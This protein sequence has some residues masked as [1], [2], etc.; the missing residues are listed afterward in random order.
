MHIALSCSAVIGPPIGGFPSC[1]PG[2]LPSWRYGSRWPGPA[3]ARGARQAARRRRGRTT[4][5]GW[6]AIAG[7]DVGEIA[8]T[9]PTGGTAARQRRQH[10]PIAPKRAM[11][12][13]DRQPRS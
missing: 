11:W 2:R 9:L 12:R 8:A 5:A 3:A 13:S 6:Q 4:A 1:P 7:A 10:R